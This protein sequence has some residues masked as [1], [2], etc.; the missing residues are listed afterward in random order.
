M[1]FRFLGGGD[2]WMALSVFVL[3]MLGMA[4]LWSMA[5]GAASPSDFSFLYKQ[6]FAAV[7]G[8]FL[9]VGIMGWDA[10]LLKSYAGPLFIAG[11]AMLA[12]VLIF[13]VERRGT[14]GWFDL[15]AASFQP[16]ELAKIILVIV[17][18]A[19]L[20][21]RKEKKVGWRV[22]LISAIPVVIYSSLVFV[23]PDF[24]SLALMLAVWA[25]MLFFAGLDRRLCLGMAGAGATAMLAGWFLFFEEFQR[26]RILTFLNPSADPL[27]SGY[28]VAQSKIAVGSGRLFGR[29]LGFGPQ[30]QL[31]YLPEAKTDFLFAAIAEGLGFVGVVLVVAAFAVFFWRIYR[32]IRDSR[33]DYSSILAFGIG[34]LFFTQMTVNISMNLGIFPVTGLPL[35]F[36]SYGGS[37][38]LS[39]LLAFGI[40][41]SLARNS[42]NMVS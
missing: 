23:Q 22:L 13:G 30:S 24:G 42:S 9:A 26:Q 5:L 32:L 10:R 12:A 19:I 6:I 4:A 3:L 20:S 25:L 2:G 39:S 1:R 33:D 11:A 31:N 21:A 14:V 40:L 17:L 37:A 29:G 18:A 35:P 28:N 38:L 16:V 41:Q 34:A 27:G 8:I 7:L 36:V 15:G